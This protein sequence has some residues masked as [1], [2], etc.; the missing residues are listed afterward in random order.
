MEV[1]IYTDGACSNNPGPGGWSAIFTKPN[2]IEIISGGSNKTTNNQMEL[3]AV[4]KAILKVIKEHDVVKSY[5]KD[6]KYVIHS[7]SAYVINAINKD[8]VTKWLLDG[9]KNAQGEDTKNKDLWRAFIKLKGE[10]VYRDIDIS[11]VKVKGHA[12]NQFNEYADQIAR[13]ESEKRRK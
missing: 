4:L 8:W 5:I 6:V 12:G 11:F 3:K 9:W 10:Y 7:D 13:E 1:K 2:G